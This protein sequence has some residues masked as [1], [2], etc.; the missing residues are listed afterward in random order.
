MGCDIRYGLEN[1]HN[2]QP[3]SLLIAHDK[4][5]IYNYNRACSICQ[6]LNCVQIL[7][8]ARLF[9]Q[10]NDPPSFSFRQRTAF[11]NRDGIAFVK[12]VPFVMR[13][14]FL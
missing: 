9:H 12:F 8:G 2:V 7:Y 4:I 11:L 3:A 1:L 14:I 6:S 10:I 5:V 13:V